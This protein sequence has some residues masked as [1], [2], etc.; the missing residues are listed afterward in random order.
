MG[1]ARCKVTLK[2]LGDLLQIPY[3]IIEVKN[4]KK[5]MFEII[6]EGQGLPRKTKNGNFPLGKIIFKRI[7][8][9]WIPFE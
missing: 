3:E 9:Y 7:N 4:S 6:I 2:L 8:A 5:G 1:M